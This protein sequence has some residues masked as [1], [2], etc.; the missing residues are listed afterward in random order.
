MLHVDYV[1][2]VLPEVSLLWQ[3]REPQ[4]HS[5]TLSRPFS[6]AEGGLVLLSP[7]CLSHF[8][9]TAVL[10]LLLKGE[11]A[12][13]VSRGVTVTELWSI[14]RKKRNSFFTQPL[15]C[16]GVWA[17]SDNCRVTD[18]LQTTCSKSRESRRGSEGGMEWRWWG[19]VAPP[20]HG[21]RH[22]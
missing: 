13:D 7:T 1:L 2:S 10:L 3:Q 5:F 9:H 14:Q 18:V 8:Q 12:V 16:M 15:W 21:C 20:L 17:D 19:E 22:N 6:P 4:H 11:Q